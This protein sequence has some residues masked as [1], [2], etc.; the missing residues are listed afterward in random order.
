MVCHTPYTHAQH[1]GLEHEL[2]GLCVR[3]T[4]RLNSEYGH[5]RTLC[6]PPATL[7]G[8]LFNRVFSSQGFLSL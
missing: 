2:D 7:W 6:A 3:R 5:G 4:A 8:L 1:K